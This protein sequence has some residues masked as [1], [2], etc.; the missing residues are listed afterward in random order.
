MGVGKRAGCSKG[1]KRSRM[2]LLL[3]TVEKGFPAYCLGV[4]EAHLVEH[5]PRALAVAGSNPAKPLRKGRNKARA[6]PR[7]VEKG[8]YCGGLHDFKSSRHGFE[9]HEAP[10]GF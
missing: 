10:R 9:S 8:R 3:G 5:K 7:G 1:K 4:H 6:T 2:A